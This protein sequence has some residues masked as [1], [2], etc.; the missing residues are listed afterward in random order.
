MLR[1]KREKVA[2]VNKATL[3]VILKLI[4]KGGYANIIILCL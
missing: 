3:D 2:W 4:D 1:T